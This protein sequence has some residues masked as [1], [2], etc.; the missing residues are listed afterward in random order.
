M[1]SQNQNL[2][3]IF[4]ALEANLEGDCHQSKDNH[5]LQ[6]N[7]ETELGVILPAKIKRQLMEKDD[8]EK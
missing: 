4:V 8:D 2:I 6:Q 7:K 1:C 3:P 5:Q